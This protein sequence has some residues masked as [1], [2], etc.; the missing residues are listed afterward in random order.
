MKHNPKVSVCIPTVFTPER[1]KD[2]EKLLQS[3]I[4]QSYGD[5]EVIVIEG[6]DYKKAKKT[7]DKFRKDLRIRIVRQ[8]SKGLVNARNECWKISTGEI[9]VFVD[10]DTI[11]TSNWLLEII[12]CYKKYSRVG[13]VGG[14][15]IIPSDFTFERDTIKFLLHASSSFEKLV[16]K[17]YF[18]LFLE[19][20]PFLIGRFFR[21]GAYSIGGMTK[22]V[23]DR[24][25][26]PIEVE[27]LEAC[28]MSFKREV[29]EQV[30]GFDPTFIGLGDYHEADLCFRV[31]KFGYKLIFN[32][33]VLVY[34]FPKKSHSGAESTKAFERMRNFATFAKRHIGFSSKLFLYFLFLMGYHFLKSITEIDLRYMRGIE[35]L[36]R[37]LFLV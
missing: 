37:G 32:P 10:D 22:K 1:E 33:K 15:A 30:G 24:L 27:F 25:N 12:R 8:K 5:F 17:L 6:R 26:H 11:V 13:G 16:R 34:H 4:T 19:N 18:L 14:P 20:K 35:G 36:F 3:L 31:R 28:N 9:C 2:I 23:I 21:S 7:L 29:L